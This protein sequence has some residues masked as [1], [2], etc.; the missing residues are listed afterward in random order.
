MNDF[1][2]KPKHVVVKK[3]KYTYI[4]LAPAPQQYR[5]GRLLTLYVQSPFCRP[6]FDLFGE[7]I[8]DSWYPKGNICDLM[9][10]FYRPPRPFP[11]K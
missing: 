6:Q 10:S 2:Y 11:Q 7:F 4:A 8:N 1:K 9:Y 5:R 3:K